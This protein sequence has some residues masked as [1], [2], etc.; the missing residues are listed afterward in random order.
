M[1]RENQRYAKLLAAPGMS[2]RQFQR[3]R[4]GRVVIVG[5]LANGTACA[6]ELAAS[7]LGRMVIVDAGTIAAGDIGGHMLFASQDVGAKRAAVLAQRLVN[8]NSDVAVEVCETPLTA[9]NADVVLA[10]ANAVVDAVPEWQTKLLCSDA[11]MRLGVPF[12]HASALGL[13]LQLFTM[14]PGR[15]ACLRCV[16]AKA[17]IE[18]LA[19]S[20]SGADLPGP[21]S[22]LAGSWQ[23]VQVLKLI[24]EIGSG[25]GSALVKYDVTRNDFEFVE[26]K[27]ASDCPDCGSNRPR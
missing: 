25:Q 27:P 22:A 23:A 3:L 8:F 14:I 17:G 5:G 19:T 24:A 20:A 6:G 21:V 9:H 4:R 7:G 1:L 2:E 18:D 10:G 11:C 26:S 15:S 16:L 12:V 13:A